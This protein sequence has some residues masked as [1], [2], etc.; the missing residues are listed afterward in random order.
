[1]SARY[2]ERAVD[3]HIKALLAELPDG[4]VVAIE[5]KAS[6]APKPE[7]ARHL[8]WLRDRIGPRFVRG[9]V[10]HTDPRT[11]RLEDRIDAVPIASLWTD[12]GTG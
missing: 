1:L 2:Q 10:L 11:F 8:A 9:A 6:A 4:D 12:L 3:R 7:M 5:I